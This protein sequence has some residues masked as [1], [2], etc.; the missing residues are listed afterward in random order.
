LA[1]CRAAAPVDSLR[2]VAGVVEDGN[3][4]NIRRG[5]RIEE[6]VLL[7]GRSFLHMEPAVDSVRKQ[8]PLVQILCDLPDVAVRISEGHRAH[9]PVTIRRA[10]DEFHS[11][12]VQ[13]SAYGIRVLDEDLTWLTIMVSG[14]ARPPGLG[15]R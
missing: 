3:I 9:T 6:R 15:V 13:F 14:V 8:A 12:R 4:Q 1:W 5:A 11:V 10:A 7:D 2:A